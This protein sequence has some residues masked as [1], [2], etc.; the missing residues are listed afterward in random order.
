MPI[1]NV[2]FTKLEKSIIYK[3]KINKGYYKIIETRK[4]LYKPLILN[5][6]FRLLKNRLN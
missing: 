1:E 5:E 6:I 3:N 2:I 4:K